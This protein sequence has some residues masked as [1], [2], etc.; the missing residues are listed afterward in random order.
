MKQSVLLVAENCMHFGENC[1]HF[2]PGVDCNICVDNGK[3]KL[4]RV[5]YPDA[6]PLIVV[7]LP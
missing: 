3:L 5:Y 2:H 7:L 1:M 6:T 4:K